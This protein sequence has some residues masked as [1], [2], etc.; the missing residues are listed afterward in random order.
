MLLKENPGNEIK[1]QHLHLI[2][3]M[4]VG[5]NNFQSVTLIF[6]ITNSLKIVPLMEWALKSSLMR[7]TF[8][9]KCLILQMVMVTS[10]ERDGGSYRA[11]NSS[12]FFL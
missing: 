12:H 5:Q 3:T 9:P 6:S 7:V 8:D 4:Y 2:F 11:H 1:L 10:I